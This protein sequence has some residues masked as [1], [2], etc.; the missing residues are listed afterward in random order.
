MDNTIETEGNMYRKSGGEYRLLPYRIPR[1]KFCDFFA[2]ENF[3][4]PEITL[5]SDLPPQGTCPYE[6]RTYHLNDFA[7]VLDA[8]PE[9]ILDDNAEISLEI[10]FYRKLQKLLTIRFYFM[11]I[12]I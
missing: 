5:H 4:F 1:Q 8:I 11:I 2:S 12:K 7:P 9:V 10:R 3:F 6:N